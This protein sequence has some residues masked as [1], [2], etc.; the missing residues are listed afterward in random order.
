ML[1]L[2]YLFST[3]F[4]ID[5]TQKYCTPASII[6]QLMLLRGYAYISLEF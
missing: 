4:L 5:N 6:Q 3:P 2:Y 1:L